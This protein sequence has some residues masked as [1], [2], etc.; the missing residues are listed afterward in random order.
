MWGRNVKFNSFPQQE[1]IFLVTVSVTYVAV[2]TL[3]PAVP[4]EGR[5]ARGPDGGDALSFASHVKTGLEK[6]G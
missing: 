6:N 4:S 2:V 1:V 5:S 3:F